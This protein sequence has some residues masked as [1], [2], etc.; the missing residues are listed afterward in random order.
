MNSQSFN[1][2]LKNAPAQED[3]VLLVL[4]EG[5]VGVGKSTLLAELRAEHGNDSSIAFVDEPVELW[6]QHGLLTAM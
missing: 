4:I 2:P 1:T 3:N 5:N 6:E